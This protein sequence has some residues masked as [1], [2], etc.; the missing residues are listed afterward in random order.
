MDKQG[1]GHIQLNTRTHAAP[2][3]GRR[4]LIIADDPEAFLTAVEPT[5]WLIDRLLSGV[6]KAC[7]LG[8]AEYP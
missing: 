2:S 5:H 8:T 6:R 1:W 3:R 4:G 7:T